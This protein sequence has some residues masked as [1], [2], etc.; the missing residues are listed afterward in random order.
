MKM[1]I[2]PKPSARKCD[3]KILL[4]LIRRFQDRIRHSKGLHH[5][6]DDV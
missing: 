2:L 6:D 5:I 4:G 3:V 1:P